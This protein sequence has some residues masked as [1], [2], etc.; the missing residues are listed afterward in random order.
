MYSDIIY[1]TDCQS[2]PL[3]SA[4]PVTELRMAAVTKSNFDIDLF[5]H[6]VLHF[7]GNVEDSDDISALP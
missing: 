3:L 6:V 2:C 4:Q 5:Q 7:D 1:V